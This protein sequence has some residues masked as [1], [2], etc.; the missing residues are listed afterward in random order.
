MRVIIFSGTT[1]GRNLSEI[2]SKNKFYHIVCV[3]TESGKLCMEENEYSAVKVGRLTEDQM[4]ALFNDTKA[5]YVIDATHPYAVFVSQNLVNACEKSDAVYVRILRTDRLSSN[6][7]ADEMTNAGC[8]KY[9][10]S[11]KKCAE[12]LIKTDGNILF[13]TGSKELKNL[14]LNDDVRKR[15]VVR[16][17]PSIESINLCNEAGIAE[18][19]II[20]MYGPHSAECNR[21][22]IKQYKIAHL[23]TKESGQTGGYFEKI[24]AAVSENI[25]IHVIKRPGEKS[26]N[27]MTVD[28]AIDMILGNNQIKSVSVKLI[29]TGPGSDKYLTIAAKEAIDSADIIFGAKRMAEKYRGEK[30][31]HEA[32]LA[33]DIIPVIDKM[34][35]GN[36]VVLFSGDS[37]FFSGATKLYAALMQYGKCGSVEIIPGISSFSM[38]AAKLGTDYSKSALLSIHGKAMDEIVSGQIRKKLEN[39]Q[40]VFLLISGIE[41]LIAIDEILNELETGLTRKNEIIDYKDEA[42]TDKSELYIDIGYNLSLTDQQIFST[43]S[44]NLLTTIDGKKDGLYIVH[45]RRK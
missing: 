41:D 23:L 21:A 6:T 1:E 40:D 25:Q 22:I 34:K 35:T 19:N 42:A 4:V 10:D 17:L 11:T 45:I 16:V 44:K 43:T 37:S 5:D 31:V 30:R 29:G 12:E 20:A 9:Y 7:S 8:I 3:A 32:Y 33:K 36:V 2:L 39:N 18:K 26:A 27:I 28:E 24:S 14:I 15:A 13:T 38:F